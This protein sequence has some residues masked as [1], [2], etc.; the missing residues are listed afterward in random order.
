VVRFRIVWARSGPA[1]ACPASRSW[2]VAL[3]CVELGL[4]VD[5]VRE[6]GVAVVASSDAVG[7]QDHLARLK[8]RRL[9]MNRR[10]QHEPDRGHRERSPEERERDVSDSRSLECWEAVVMSGHGHELAIG[11]KGRSLYPSLEGHD[12]SSAEDPMNQIAESEQ[13]GRLERCQKQE[14]GPLDTAGE[15][16]G[17]ALAVGFA[18]L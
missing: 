10:Q 9:L 13:P 2:R 8:R 4:S 16:V 12:E 15:T 14:G 17:R 3:A 7:E 1:V 18:S 6:G 11:A 5:D